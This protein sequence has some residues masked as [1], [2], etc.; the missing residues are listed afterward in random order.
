MAIGL[1]GIRRVDFGEGAGGILGDGP[2]YFE[3]FPGAAILYVIGAVLLLLPL[4]YWSSGRI[5]RGLRICLCLVWIAVFLFQAIPSHGFWKSGTLMGE[6]ANASSLP[7]PYFLAVWIQ[8][9]ALWTQV[10]A[11]AGNLIF[12]LFMLFMAVISLRSVPPRW[13]LWMSMTGLFWSWWFAQDFGGVFSGMGMDLNSIPLIG[14]LMVVGW[15]EREYKAVKHGRVIH[16]EN[17]FHFKPN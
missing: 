2:N 7:Q 14:L 8:A 10:H 17:L 15:S 13:L 12:M 5:Y 3:G 4:Q 9:F 11:A 1:L 6:L 16:Y